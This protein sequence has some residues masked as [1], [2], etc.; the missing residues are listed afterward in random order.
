MVESSGEI[1]RDRIKV[2]NH[3][4][5]M[6]LNHGAVHEQEVT[7]K[8][9]ASRKS[10]NVGILK[11]EAESGHII[12]I[13]LQQ[14]QYLTRRKSLRSC[15]QI[16]G[17][18]PTDLTWIDLDEN[19]AIWS[20]FMN[21]TLQAAVH[22][23]RD[24]C[25][26][27]RT[28]K[29]QSSKVCGAIFPYDWKVDHGSDRNRWSWPRLITMNLRGDRL[30]YVKKRLRLRMSS[31]TRCSVWEVSVTNQSK[32]G[33][34]TLNGIWKIG[35]SKIWIELMESQSSCQCTTTLFVENEGNTETCTMNS[36]TVCELCSQILARTLVTSLGPGSEK[37]WYTELF[38][39][40]SDGDWDKTAELMMLNFAE[41]GQP[42]FRA[43]SALE[44]GALR[45][46]GKEKEVYSL[47]R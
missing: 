2:R 38:S 32:L 16:Y 12:F 36:V 18:S 9:V 17:R 33:R 11:L 28:V 27:L 13:C 47:Q 23:G 21:V 35:I 6:N 30:L 3:G 24:Y 8:L 10:E 46:R 14:Q 41:S 1:S 43:T 29:N 26:N 20:I 31:P 15:R 40:K 7:G 22:L 37:K 4:N 39:D 34:T 25:A 5:F 42:I 44:G 45:S 19:N